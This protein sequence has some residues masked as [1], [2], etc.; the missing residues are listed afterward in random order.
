ML[1]YPLE[2]KKD[3][4]LYEQLYNDIRRDIVSGALGAGEK[5]PSKR[6][7]A[8]HLEISVVTVENAYEQLMAEGYIRAEEKRGYYVCPVEMPPGALRPLS[9]EIVEPP[10][11]EWFLDFVTNSTAAEFFPFDTWA[12][13]MRRTILDKSTDLLRSTPSIGALELR[14]A[15]AAWLLA[16][17]GMTVSPGQIIL[18]AGTE[19]LYSLLIKLLGR[20]K[21][22]AVEDPGYG[23]IAGIYKSEGVPVCR[24]YLDQNGLN[25]SAL[26]QSDA[27]VVHISPSH[28]YPTGIVMPIGRRQE[29]LR[30]AGERE[31][32]Y[33]LEDEYD[34]E[35]RFVGRPIPTLFSSDEH[36]RVIYLNT[37]S[38]TIAPSIRV[39]YM[40]LP[41][42]LLAEY[43]RRLGFYACPVSSFEQYTLAEFLAN[44]HYEHHLSRMKTRYHKKR[45][46]VIDAIRAGLPRAEIMEQDAGL[47]FLVR[48][49][50]D[51][52]DD[53]LQRRAANCGIRLALL[54]HYYSDPHQA[55]SH[56]LVVNYSGIQLQRL[57]EGLRRLNEVWEEKD[58]V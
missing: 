46:A 13:L 1:T 27:D 55:P 34:S 39:S 12:R 29:L 57:E 50:T 20:D 44:G 8:R 18:G 15:I 37:F 52:P 2:K 23:K 5:L 30:W 38:K 16:F 21:R 6:A 43:H 40:I 32:R 36:Q 56:V 24:I 7:L 17:R 28:H 45:D 48:L 9:C 47:H 11:R 14:Q 54:S 22:Y 26:R 42:H 4:S 3:L 10:E 35:F 33:V 31:N 53:E 58:H 41:P 49:D 25:V 19:S 51:L